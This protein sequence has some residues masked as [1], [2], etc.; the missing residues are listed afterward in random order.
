MQQLNSR[1]WANFPVARS[2]A[3]WAFGFSAAAAFGQTPIV[4]VRSGQVVPAGADSL[5]VQSVNQ[6][7]IDEAGRVLIDANVT[8]SL[9]G[10]TEQ[11]YFMWESGSLQFLGNKRTLSIAMNPPRTQPLQTL[12]G[13]RQSRGGNVYWL[14]YMQASPSEDA[15][16]MK[17]PGEPAIGITDSE[18]PAPGVLS[19]FSPFATP[20]ASNGIIVRD[21]NWDLWT[22]D[23]S[24]LPVGFTRVF[25][26]NAQATDL[27]AGVLFNGGGVRVYGING[28]NE[29]AFVTG[30]TGTGV[31]QSQ[32]DEAVYRGQGSSQSLVLRRGGSAPGFASGTVSK[33]PTTD[34]DRLM[35]HENGDLTFNAEVSVSATFKKCVYAG[36]ATALTPILRAGL[37][38]IAGV[39]GSVNEIGFGATENAQRVL[40]AG[41]NPN[42]TTNGYTRSLLFVGSDAAPSILAQSGQPVP[43]QPGSVFSHVERDPLINELGWVVFRGGYLNPQGGSSLVYGVFG[44]RDGPISSRLV[45]YGQTLEVAPGV[46]KQV[47]SI[48]AWPVRQG[49]PQF[50]NS[51]TM[52]TYV[53]FTDNSSAVLATTVP[54]AAPASPVLVS[55]A[56]NALI[57]SQ[58][59]VLSWSAALGAQSYLVTIT[60]SGSAPQTFPVTTTSFAV[61]PGVVSDCQTVTWSVSAVNNNGSTASIPFSRIFTTTGVDCTYPPTYTIEKIGLTNGI[62][63]G[64]VVRRHTPEGYVAGESFR[65]DVTSTTGTMGADAWLYD[66]QTRGPLGLVG[67]IYENGGLAQ[68]YRVSEVVAVNSSGSA[69]GWSRRHQGGGQ[70]LRGTDAWLF[71][72]LSTQLIGLVGPGYE[73]TPGDPATRRDTSPVAINA[74]GDIAGATTRYSASGVYLGSDAWLR[75]GG[76][77]QVIGPTGPQYDIVVAAG[78]RRDASVFGMNDAGR[79][80]GWIGRSTSSGALLGQDSWIRDQNGSLTIL[81]LTGPEFE[82]A[83]ANGVIRTTRATLLNTAGDVAGTVARYNAAGTNLGDGVFFHRSGSTQIVDPADVWHSKAVAGGGF[84][85]R[86]LL[87][88]MSDSG[89]VAGHSD[90][91]DSL[92]NDAGSTAWY[93][94]GMTTVFIG[95]TGPDYEGTSPN[96]NPLLRGTSQ[97]LQ[98]HRDGRVLGRNYVYSA[99][100]QQWDIWVYDPATQQ[101]TRVSTPTPTTP[102]IGGNSAMARNGVVFSGTLATPGTPFIWSLSA[103]AY[104]VSARVVGGLPTTE[105]AGVSQLISGSGDSALGWPDL[106]AGLGS[107]VS[108]PGPTALVMRAIPV[109]SGF[110]L[111]SPTPGQSVESPQTTLAWTPA[112]STASYT[113]QLRVNAGALQEFVTTQASFTI[114][115]GTVAS[116]DEVTWG[117]IASDA[118]G[119]RRSTLDSQSFRYIAIDM[120]RNGQVSVQDLFTYLA[121]WFGGQPIA[122]FNG[123]DGIS[124]QDI[125]DFLAAWFQGC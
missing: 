114:P 29:Y 93:F 110:Q 66:G 42:G 32:N 121:L 50:N 33:L 77:T 36:P 12:G 41:Y 96:P 6:Q 87:K 40:W 109:P 80:I 119:S 124:V 79:I 10:S 101:T 72:G 16:L 82:A 99:P 23:V 14:A 68:P 97:V 27:P 108:A 28:S 89:A 117:V 49:I 65:G 26:H 47:S 113:V 57:S 4:I 35:I 55:P 37:N 38:T 67:T 123:V 91:Y 63:T 56:V 1:T 61:P 15:V 115:Q 88:G 18:A 103:G 17:R 5:T 62:Y 31:V 46:S 104:P 13:A 100:P 105:W 25:Q 21:A 22:G 73:A 34:L 94:N 52:L 122:D 24:S 2:A 71:D 60:P 102:A 7:S 118:G 43:G 19:V 83:S 45:S 78:L 92:G 58:N 8:S 106:I 3:L 90:R 95:L 54:L 69:I 116:C 111:V 64:S 44:Y 75:S 9:S 120:D 81:S 48:V 39:S 20:N 98:V 85:R 76:T 53:L 86:P 70:T 125:F 112:G 11:A 74:Q 30:L 59:I 51:G 84:S 107:Y